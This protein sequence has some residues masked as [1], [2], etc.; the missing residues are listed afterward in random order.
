MLLVFDMTCTCKRITPQ[1]VIS[2]DTSAGKYTRN[3]DFPRTPRLSTHSSLVLSARMDPS[4]PSAGE[5]AEAVRDQFLNE[6]IEYYKELEDAIANAAAADG[7]EMCTQEHV[8]AG[9]LH[10]DPD[11]ADHVVR[12][13]SQNLGMFSKTVVVPASPCRQAP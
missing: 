10:L 1:K 6:R 2:A 3:S 5:F 12:I 8:K 7:M 13:I 4:W 9:L 11:M